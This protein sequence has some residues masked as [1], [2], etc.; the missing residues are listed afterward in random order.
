M[1]A[2]CY[3]NPELVSSFLSCTT[4]FFPLTSNNTNPTHNPTLR[5]LPCTC[6]RSRG[7]TANDSRRNTWQHNAGT[8]NHCAILT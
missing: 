3:S 5:Y 8:L 7:S 1:K 4:F 2:S 6:V